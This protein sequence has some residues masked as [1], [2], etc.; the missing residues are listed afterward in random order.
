MAAETKHFKSNNVLLGLI[1]T[2]FEGYA[3]RNILTPDQGSR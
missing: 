2:A 3:L 1:F